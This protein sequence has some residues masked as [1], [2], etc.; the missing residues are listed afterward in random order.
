MVSSSFSSPE[1]DAFS[2][3]R[4]RQR[5]PG[6]VQPGLGLFLA[7]IAGAADLIELVAKLAAEKSLAESRVDR[8]HL[9]AD[10]IVWSR[11]Q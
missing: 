9:V 4:R 5:R 8:S 1:L 10:R 2:L 7:R 6:K 3:H 11:G